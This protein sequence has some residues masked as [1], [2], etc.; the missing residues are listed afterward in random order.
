VEAGGDDT[1]G[2]AQLHRFDFTIRD[3]L[4]EL[5]AT[6]TDHASGVVDPDTNWVNRR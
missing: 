6:D 3:Q 2:F 1:S 4:V 5:G